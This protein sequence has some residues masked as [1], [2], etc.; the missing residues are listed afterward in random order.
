MA[1]AICSSYSSSSNTIIAS[2]SLIASKR[3]AKGNFSKENSR[4]D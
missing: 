1:R 2:V 4:N 3:I